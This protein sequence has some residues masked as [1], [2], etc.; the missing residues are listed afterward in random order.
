MSRFKSL[1]FCAGLLGGL[2]GF[3]HAARL[4]AKAAECGPSAT[5]RCAAREQ[6]VALVIGNSNYQNAPQL[7]NPDNDAQSMA[8]LLNSAGFEVI[9]ATDLTQNDMVK[10]VQD[11][12]AKVAARGPE[13]GCD[14]LLRRPRRAARRRELPR[15]GRRQD[16]HACR[17]RRQLGAPRRRDGDAGDDP[18]PDAHR[19]ARRLPQQSVPRR[20]R[21]RA[22]SCHRRRA[23]RLDRRLF[24]GAGHRKRRTAPAATARIRRPSCASRASRI[25]RSSNCS[26][27]SASK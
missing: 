12:S 26:S 4:C 5:A 20:Q 17:A 3:A 21:C 14:G 18:E 25:C 22:G 8:Q 15:P 6:R 24:D 11:F 7:A 23:E 9:A 27:A 19:R 10:V 2:L 16:F 13:H 1:L